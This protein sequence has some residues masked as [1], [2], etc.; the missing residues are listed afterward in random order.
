MRPDI[1]AI[2]AFHAA[3]FKHASADTFIA[4][5]A[6][7]DDGTQAPPFSIHAIPVSEAVRAVHEMAKR[8]AEA[9]F[10]VVVAPPIATFKGRAGAAESDLAE[11]VALSVDCDNS[12]PDAALKMLTKLLGKPTVTVASGG[13]W[14]AP[15]TGEVRDRLHLHWRLSVPTRDLAGHRRLKLARELA[16]RLVGGDRSAGPVVHPFRWPGTAHMKQLPY[17]QARIKS[18]DDSRE[19][20]LDAAL[21]ALQGALGGEGRTNLDLGF[22]TPHERQVGSHSILLAHDVSDVVAVLAAIPND[23]LEWDEWNK[24]GLAAYSASGGHDAGYDAWLAWSA[25]SEKHDNATCRERWHHYQRHKGRND[26]YAPHERRVGMGT[27]VHLARQTDPDWQLPSKIVRDARH[28][29]PANGDGCPLANLDFNAYRL[30]HLAS[31]TPPVRQFLLEPIMPLG[32]VGLLFGEGGLGKSMEALALAILVARAGMGSPPSG[33]ALQG[34]FGGTVPKC[35][36]GASIFLTLEDDRAEIH[37]RT[38]A[39]DAAGYR[40]GAPCYVI[41]ALDL[42]GFD[43]ALITTGVGRIAT[44]TDFAIRGL[45]AMVINVSRESGHPVRLII[46]DPAGDFLD[47]DENDAGPVKRLLRLLREKASAHG[48]TILLLGHVAKSGGGTSMRGSSA[49]VANARFAYSLRRLDEK[50]DKNALKIFNKEGFGID[51]LVIGCLT[52]ANHAGAS[53]N[54]DRFFV[55]CQE[56][57]RLIDHTHMLAPPEVDETLLQALVT[58]CGECAAVGQPF[59]LTG[60]AGLYAGRASLGAPLAD[61][62]RTR[63]EALGN[64][65]VELGRLVKCSGPG[66]RAPDFLD[67]PTGPFATKRGVAPAAGSRE[68]ALTIGRRAK[69]QAGDTMEGAGPDG[70]ATVAA[71]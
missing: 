40:D 61:L 44:L 4:A 58:R 62:T 35:S 36:G 31:G 27:L 41:P 20:D 65:A 63:L 47:A 14:T 5:R 29:A 1:D 2:M 6:F 55:R 56:T 57:G 15:E 19:I 59:K 32:V 3:L 39:V 45:D 46:L 34:P 50:D 17:R 18:L 38:M 52:K 64:K 11:G 9:G 66:S 30:D 48:C 28:E 33:L 24:I 70:T 10:P 67:I 8:A 21:P 12:D 49:W 60:N 22:A 25:K 69:S 23:N 16:A 71:E 51:R 54:R 53:L 13:E 7:R 26:N 43:P 37:R 42:P 68:E